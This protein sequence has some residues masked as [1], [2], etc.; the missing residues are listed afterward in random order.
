MPKKQSKELLDLIRKHKK[1]DKMVN[2]VNQSLNLTIELEAYQISLMDCLKNLRVGACYL[3]QRDELTE[4]EKNYL[5]NYNWFVEDAKIIFNSYSP[6]EKK[7]I[8]DCLTERRKQM[9]L[10]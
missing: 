1:I 9:L 5:D 6:T 8:F 10:S 4:L 7:E 3:I 2:A